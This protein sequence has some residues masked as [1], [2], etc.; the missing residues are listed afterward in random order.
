MTDRRR[1]QILRQARRHLERTTKGYVEYERTGKGSEWRRALE[2][3]DALARS[4]EPSPV[5]DLGPVWRG[6]R[7]VLEHDLTHATSGLP[8]YP[9]FD[10]AF[11]AGVEVI[12]PEDLVVI[13]PRTSARPGAAFYARGRS[14][15]RYWFGHLDRAPDPGT[16][17]VTGQVMARVAHHPGFT[18]HVHVGINVE[19]LLGE[20]KELEHHRDYTHGA[21]TVGEQ[22]RRLL[23]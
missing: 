8:R 12:A 19:L 14:K 10:D 23:G 17:Y 2:A 6:G 22:L 21:P 16:R 9:A 4:L 7:S 3:L 5:P 18:P 11:R 15:I 13:P 20:G 1:L